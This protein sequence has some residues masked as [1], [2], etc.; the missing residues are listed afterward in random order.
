MET[1][2]VVESKV[3]RE[4]RTTRKT[5]RYTFDEKLKAVR[6]FV[7]EGFPQRLVCRETGGSTSSLAEWVR[8]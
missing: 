2:E 5:R 4:P 1:K 3:V 7:Q 8:G 6:L